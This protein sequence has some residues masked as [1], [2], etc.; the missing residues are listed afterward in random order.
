MA[1]Y[2]SVRECPV[3]GSQEGVDMFITDRIYYPK[4]IES[5]IQHRVNTVLKGNV[6]F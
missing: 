2:M 5:H 6:F 1:C 3:V 4:Q